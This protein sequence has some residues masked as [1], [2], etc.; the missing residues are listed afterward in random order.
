M[1][2]HPTQSY[3]HGSTFNSPTRR[4]LPLDC[5]RPAG[6]KSSITRPHLHA[7]IFFDYPGQARQ[8]VSMRELRLK[9]TSTPIQGANDLLFAHTGLQRV[10]FRLIWP[11]YEHVEWCRALPVVAPNGAPITRVALGLQIASNFAHFVE[12][13]QYETP[14]AREW[15]ITPTCVRFEHLF[16]VSLQNTSEGIWQ[17]DVALDLC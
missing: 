10:V 1:S 14:T 4:R 2:Y 7:P 9:G 17:A 12:K 15:M 3:S 13:S 16:L 6:W 11:G 5:Y 8:G